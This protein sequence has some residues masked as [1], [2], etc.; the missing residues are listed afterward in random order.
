MPHEGDLI[1][2][3]YRLLKMIG[4]GGMGVVFEA[5]HIRTGGRVAIKFLSQ[6][7]ALDDSAVRR[8]QLEAKAAAGIGHEG[9]VNVHDI[10]FSDS[11]EHY[12][13]MELLRGRSLGEVLDERG[14][15]EVDE[16]AAILCQVLSAL[17]AAHEAGIVHRDMKP[18]NVFLIETG[19]PVPGVKLLDFGISRTVT[20][21]SNVETKT[22]RLT[23]AGTVLGTPYYMSSEQAEGRRDI[24]HRTDL[25]AVGV[26]LYE[27]LTGHLPF[28]GSS[29]N[30]LLAAVLT[31]DPAP[32]RQFRPDLPEALEAVIERSLDKD[33]ERRYQSAAELF[34]A[35]SPFVDEV[36]LGR[37]A[38]PRGLDEVAQTPAPVPPFSPS[39]D[40]AAMT[41]PTPRRWGS[42]HIPLA[43]I[44]GLGA[45]VVTSGLLYA[46]TRSPDHEGTQTEG[47][48]NA[49]ELYPQ[50]PAQDAM[51]PPATVTV[52]LEGLPEDAQVFVDGALVKERPIT[53]QR[54]DEQ[55]R[56]E[57]KAEGY[58][59]FAH[60]L[61]PTEDVTIAVILSE[62]PVDT[63]EE[64][65]VTPATTKGPPT[66]SVKAKQT[67]RETSE[68]SSHPAASGGY[69][70]SF[71]PEKRPTQ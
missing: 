24:D 38:P 9:I 14:Q 12:L 35:L 45:L 61:R 27:A 32:P 17:S 25:Y 62:T 63:P 55:R 70:P 20:T 44:G 49:M 10:G 15:L 43:I 36:A 37:I 21:D 3:K 28:K 56:L 1:D 29:Y 50:E 57:V 60:V 59:P 66:R 6:D 65:P 26:I 8:F 52:D 16:V 68:E 22:F 51:D 5:E 69:E 7:A 23:Q 42:G 47:V 40:T 64:T 4:E 30:E 58:R 46:L 67:H 31:R 53:L 48:T 39:V 19:A 13:V 41:T 2:Q 33:R 54:S 34:S 71:F 11:G 18:D